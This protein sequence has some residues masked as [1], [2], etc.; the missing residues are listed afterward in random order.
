MAL[1]YE[2]I[3]EKS[4]TNNKEMLVTF[5]SF[6]K[7]DSIKLS[8]L[9]VYGLYCIRLQKNKSLPDRYNRYLP[10]NRYVYIGKAKDQTLK[11]RLYEQELNAIGHGTF[12]RS[13]GAV[14]GYRPEKGSLANKKNKCNYKFSP[15][16]TKKIIS[17]IKNN[18]EV[19]WVEVNRDFSIEKQL[20]QTH[21]P[22][23]NWSYNPNKI[24]ELKV[25]RAECREIACNKSI[26][27]E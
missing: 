23:L 20:I 9:E 19:S 1:K 10:S 8:E 24:N 14:L 22:L 4:Q 2:S 6:Q 3:E 27:V 15:E 13:I 21:F 26:R 7:I 16:D 12:F 5:K 25:D 11:E 17:W 18:L